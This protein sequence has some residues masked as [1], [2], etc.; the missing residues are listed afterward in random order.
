MMEKLALD[1]EG[2]GCAPTP[3]NYIY[4]HVQSCVRSNWK[5][6]YE[7]TPAISNLLLYTVKY[8]PVGAEP[9]I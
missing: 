9:N 8:P 2:G 4:H 6:W 7:Y 3:F 1:D 5:G